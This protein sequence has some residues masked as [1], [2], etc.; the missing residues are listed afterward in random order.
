MKDHLIVLIGA[1]NALGSS[2]Q[3]LGRPHLTFIQME[4]SKRVVLDLFTKGKFKEGVHYIQS[5]LYMQC[6]TTKAV[7]PVQNMIAVRTSSQ[8]H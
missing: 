3:Y 8:R 6:T 5:S 2:N 1:V 7:F 4:P